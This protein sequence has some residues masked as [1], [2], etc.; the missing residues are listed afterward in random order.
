MNLS[1][2]EYLTNKLLD[3]MGDVD[4]EF[5]GFFFEKAQEYLTNGI[6]A[7]FPIKTVSKMDYMDA[8]EKLDSD[9]IARGFSFD[10]Y[11][12]F[13]PKVD[14]LL[15]KGQEE[16]VRLATEAFEKLKTYRLT[17]NGLFYFYVLALMFYGGVYEYD[18]EEVTKD[19]PMEAFD[20]TKAYITA[21]KLEKQFSES[22]FN[23][24]STVAIKS[25][26][27]IN[28]EDIPP[29]ASPSAYVYRDGYYYLTTDL[30]KE[31]DGN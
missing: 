25:A 3:Y 20:T 8:L 28:Y 24:A 1:H 15:P 7:D 26:Q 2:H 29:F 14:Y 22:E 30:L 19:F 6:H 12:Q 17:V 4:G 13:E 23:L 10:W 31:H 21:K 11:P 16:M 5:F 18:S 9:L 27:P